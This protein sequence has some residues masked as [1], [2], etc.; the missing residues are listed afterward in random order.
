MIDLTTVHTLSSGSSGNALVLSTENTHIL[1]D[2]GISCRRI[3]QG[4]R[5][6]GLELCDLSA[7]LISHTHSDHIS[8]LAT[9]VKRCRA[10]IYSSYETARGLQYR[11]AGVEDLLR[12]FSQGVPFEVDGCR[13]TPFS[14]C[15]DAPGSTA[16][17]IDTE[18]GGFGFLTDSGCIPDGAR[19]VLPGVE[20][21]LLEANHDVDTLRSGSYPYYLK[22][23]ILGDNGHLSNEAAASFAAEA[24]GWGASEIVLAHLSEE[25][26]T[27]AMARS[28]VERSLAAAGL[29]PRL[30]VAPRSALSECHMVGAGCR[31]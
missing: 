4:L 14:T 12:P 28:A 7:L 10:P 22:R 24:A 18:E 13:V 31:R 20:L 8:G 26:N 11:I 1:L 2:A 5:Q 17:R 21:L 23:R 19:E 6:L 9:L 29:S 3:E 27:P 16:Y 30:T 25:N 15:H